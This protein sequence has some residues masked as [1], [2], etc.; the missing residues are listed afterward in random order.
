M[1]N[2][3]HAI[4]ELFSS[5]R[6]QPKPG[7]TREIIDNQGLADPKTPKYSLEELRTR[8]LVCIGARKLENGKS[9]DAEYIEE[10]SLYMGTWAI[11]KTGTGKS[12]FILST[13][14]FKFIWSHKDVPNAIIIFDSNNA[15]MD[16]VITLCE[17]YK[18]PYSVL[19]ETG[20]NILDTGGDIGDDATALCDAYENYLTRSQSKDIYFLGYVRSWISTVMPLIYDVYGEKPH[21]LDI[22]NLGTDPQVR[23]WLIEDAR[24][25]GLNEDNSASFFDYLMQFNEKTEKDKEKTT[26]NLTGLVSYLRQIIIG[27]NRKLLCQK[28]AKTLDQRIA[29]KEVIF[30]TKV[31]FDGSLENLIGHLFLSNIARICNHRETYT[32]PHP[33]WIFIDEMAQLQS[34]L[35]GNILSECRK[36]DMGFFMASQN[37]GQIKFDYRETIQAN[38]RTRIVLSDLPIDTAKLV[39]ESLGEAKYETKETSISRNDDGK[40]TKQERVS[41]DYDLIV[42][43]EE[44]MNLPRTEAVVLTPHEGAKRTHM[45]VIKPFLKLENKKRYTKPNGQLEDPK[46]IWQIQGR[47]KQAQTPPASANVN[48]GKKNLLPPKNGGSANGNSGKN[49]GQKNQQPQPQTSGNSNGKQNNRPGSGGSSQQL[50]HF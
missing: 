32:N 4:G 50:P 19:P 46:T 11:S 6:S 34:Q 47:Y 36:K 49:Q 38:A 15:L 17:R 12:I 16:D 45:H 28:N 5:F 27:E 48:A 13:Y 9:G 33:L 37:Y 21:I 22:I 35:L 40:V 39:A 3:L 31:G 29:D 18:K 8:N 14:L 43:P 23:K 26:Y 1:G 42:R 20:I 41:Q 10:E 2:L 30:I 25:I 7:Y 24:S 44:L